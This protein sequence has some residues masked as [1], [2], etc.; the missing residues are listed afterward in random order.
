MWS[1]DSR[2]RLLTAEAALRPNA[3]PRGALAYRKDTGA[4]YASKAAKL[5]LMDA[6]PQSNGASSTSQRIRPCCRESVILQ[7]RRRSLKMPGAGF[8][9]KR[10]RVGHGCGVGVDPHGDYSP[11]DFKLRGSSLSAQAISP[12]GALPHRHGRATMLF[13]RSSCGWWRSTG[14]RE[15]TCRDGSRSSLKCTTIGW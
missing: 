7:R 4:H 15:L 9:A 8:V 10:T 3:L 12:A 14:R 6:P 5:C 2:Q 11:R 13:G 1:G